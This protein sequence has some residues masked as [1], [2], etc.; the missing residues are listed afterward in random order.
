MKHPR[1]RPYPTALDRLK[2]RA[3]E[4]YEEIR[5]HDLIVGNDLL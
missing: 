4:A 2:N 1:L 3:R 5:T